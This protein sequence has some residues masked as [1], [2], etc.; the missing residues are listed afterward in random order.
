MP[1]ILKRSPRVLII[2]EASVKPG[3]DKLQ[4]IFNYMH[5]YGPWHLDMIQ[6]RASERAI[7]AWSNQRGEAFRQTG[8]QAGCSCAI[9]KVPRPGTDWKRERRVLTRW[10]L[11]LPKPA[12]VLTAMDT[13][14]SSSKHPRLLRRRAYSYPRVIPDRHTPAGCRGH[15]GQRIYQDQ[16]G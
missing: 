7:R 11:S 15:P 14:A 12:G 4:G 8:K 2:Q 5:L 6:S 3:R 9:Y 1:S 13:R 10:L 16:R